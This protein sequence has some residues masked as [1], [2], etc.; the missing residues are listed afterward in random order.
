MSAEKPFD[1]LKALVVPLRAPL[2]VGT[3]LFITWIIFP[4]GDPTSH[5]SLTINRMFIARSR[6]LAGV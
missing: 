4:L 2:E 5:S 3:L 6:C 1:G